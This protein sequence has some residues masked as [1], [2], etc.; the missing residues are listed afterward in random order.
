MYNMKLVLAGPDVIALDNIASAREHRNIMRMSCAAL[1]R[2]LI[3][4]NMIIYNNMI[5]LS[6]AA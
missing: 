2:D 6:C 1:V 3:R 4:Y 5:L